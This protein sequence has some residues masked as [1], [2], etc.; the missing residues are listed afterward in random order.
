MAHTL[1]QADFSVLLALARHIFKQSLIK[2]IKIVTCGRCYVGQTFY[3]IRAHQEN[4]FI[5]GPEPASIS[6]LILEI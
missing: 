4:S 1:G 3:I 6:A 5:K 2:K